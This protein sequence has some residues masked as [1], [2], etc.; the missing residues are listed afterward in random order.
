M[1]RI[2]EIFSSI[3]GEGPLTG[4]L[5][6]WIR[7]FGCN[8]KCDGFFQDDPTDP[9]TYDLPYK[10]IE[11]TDVTSLDQ[12]PVFEKCC[13]SSYSWDPRYKHLAT[14]F[15]NSS[16]L[17]D[18]ILKLLPNGEWRHP[19]TRNQID[20]C[21]TGGEP[22][23]QQKNVIAILDELQ[24]RNNVPRT[25]QF[26]TNGTQ[27]LSSFFTDSYML[28]QVKLS[29]RIDFHFNISPKLFNVS[30]ESP[31][32]SWNID[33]LKQM[34]SYGTMNF[35]FV[36]N[37]REETWLELRE[38]VEDIQNAGIHGIPI[39]IM[40]VGSTKEQ[41]EDPEVISKI[42]NRAIQEG[43]HVSGR[44]HCTFFGNTIGV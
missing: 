17:V 22:L 39:F 11:L 27:N 18:E 5:S 31:E 44:T 36:V 32:D 25:V 26:E 24:R 2:S 28:Y 10:R 16:D 20:L 23:M 19:V 30:G 9:S 33:A 14:T 4:R 38:R 12:L 42:V 7:F 13:D 35:K 1:I 15:K 37:N 3:Q 40:L 29:T 34:W 6:I 43:Y 21:F 41:Q 8:L